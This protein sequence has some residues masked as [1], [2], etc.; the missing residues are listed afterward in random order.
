MNALPYRLA[1]DGMKCLRRFGG[2]DS[3][4]LAVMARAPCKPNVV[5][6]RAYG[7]PKLLKSS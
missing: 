5:D 3:F 1:S 4:R 2:W 7:T 6:G